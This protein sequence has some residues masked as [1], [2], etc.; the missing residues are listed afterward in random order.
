MPS[1][2]RHDER[3]FAPELRAIERARK[4]APQLRMLGRVHSLLGGA[5]L[6]AGLA[7]SIVL[8]SAALF[9]GGFPSELMALGGAAV[10]ALALLG[11]PWLAFGFGLHR[12]RSWARGLGIVLA[13]LLLPFAPLGSA[14]GVWTLVVLL[15]W[16]PDLARAAGAD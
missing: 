3:E 9:A 15:A 6:A 10:G 13:A 12:R 16:R 5:A 8:S 1:R 11:V 14:L 7:L 4:L 2:A